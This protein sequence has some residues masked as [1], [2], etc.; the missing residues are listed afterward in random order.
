MT[1]GI[2]I[3]VAS[4]L[5]AEYPDMIKNFLELWSLLSSSR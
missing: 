4:L 3:A 1:V 5:L 2:G